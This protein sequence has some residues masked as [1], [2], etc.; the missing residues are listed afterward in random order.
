MELK[1]FKN[2]DNRTVV[3]TFDR[4]VSPRVAANFVSKAYNGNNGNEQTKVSLSL[5]SELVFGHSGRYD[6]YNSREL[7]F[8]GLG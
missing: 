4:E 3:L 7:F 5:D 1:N 8:I 2:H 6:I